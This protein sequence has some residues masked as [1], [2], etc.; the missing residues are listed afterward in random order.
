MARG[1]VGSVPWIVALIPLLVL[2]QTI[3]GLIATVVWI[4][5]IG[6][7]RLAGRGRDRATRLNHDAILILCCVGAFLLGGLYFAPAAAAFWLVDRG[8]PSATPV[9]DD[10]TVPRSG[11]PMSFYLGLA[12]CVVGTAGIA[13]FLLLPTYMSASSSTTSD[14]TTVSTGTVLQLGLEP[15]AI[16]VLTLIGVLFAAVAV[17]STFGSRSQGSKPVLLGSAVLGLLVATIAGGFSVGLFI[18]PGALLAFVT[19][20]VALVERGNA[21]PPASPP[22]SL[23]SAR[24]S[25]ESSAYH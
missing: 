15:Q 16:V 4:L 12:A 5:V 13:A 24:S 3:V 9:A 8:S 14:I 2:W 22:G 25:P 20:T 10:M 19:F 11:R 17:I 18:A 7:F 6:S 21:T 1:F 23:E